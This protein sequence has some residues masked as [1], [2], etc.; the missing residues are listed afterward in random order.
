[1]RSTMRDWRN[2]EGAAAFF[3]T[4]L[5]DSCWGGFGGTGSCASRDQAGKRPRPAANPSV[6]HFHEA[7]RGMTGRLRRGGRGEGERRFSYDTRRGGTVLAATPHWS[8]A[9]RRR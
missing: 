7:G 4:S 6:F 1:M 8:A 5:A 3:A 9:A 2:V